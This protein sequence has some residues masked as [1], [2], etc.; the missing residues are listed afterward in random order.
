M[1]EP[2]FPLFD[3]G[4][5]EAADETLRKE[6]AAKINDACCFTGF[7]AVSGHGVPQD[8]IDDVWQA[9]R[10]FF[11]LSADEKHQVAPPK[12]GYPY[13]YLGPG[14]EALAKSRGQDTPPDLK[15]SFNGGP[16]NTPAGMTDPD[17]LSFCFQPTPWPNSPVGFQAKWEAYYAHME[18]LAERVMRGFA[19]ALDLPVEF[20][21]P[22]IDAPISALRA[23]NYPAQNK[24]PEQGQLR[25][26]AHTDYGSLTI[27]LPEPGSQGLQIQTKDG[28]WLPV[29]PISGAFIINIGDLMQRWTGGRWV[30]TLHRVVTPLDWAGRRRQSLA[31]FHQPNWDAKIECL[32]TC[33]PPN[34]VPNSE[35]VLSGPYLMQRFRA[36]TT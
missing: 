15:E 20:F 24:P 16:R 28:D 29:P 21:A 3:L 19:M 34:G 11:D 7:L 12:P 14:T 23:L 30:S 2:K 32:P 17:A 31:F 36:A 18:G 27:L 26:G 6:M 9:A 4:A 33:L 25:A 13:G 10:G 35:T 8:G 1:T 5:F 22:Y